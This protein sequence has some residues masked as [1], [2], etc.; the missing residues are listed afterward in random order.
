MTTYSKRMSIHIQS[1]TE[2][3]LA[4][5]TVRLP[6]HEPY[7]ETRSGHKKLLDALRV[8]QRSM[9]DTHAWASDREL[10]GCVLVAAPEA[11]PAQEKIRGWNTE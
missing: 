2:S 11:V 8:V 5:L 10:A 4:I 9:T 1:A 7:L 3:W 6:P